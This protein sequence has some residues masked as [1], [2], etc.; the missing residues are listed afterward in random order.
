[1]LSIFS[2]Y[3]NVDQEQI[4]GE[5]AAYRGVVNRCLHDL[6]VLSFETHK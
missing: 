1:M 5:G 2:I 4:F 6:L 3:V